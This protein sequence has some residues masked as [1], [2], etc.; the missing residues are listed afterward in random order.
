VDI[1]EKNQY[2]AV[3]FLVEKAKN[4]EDNITFDEENLENIFNR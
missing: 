4:S 2:K 1:D 3:L